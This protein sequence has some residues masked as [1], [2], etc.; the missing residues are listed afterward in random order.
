MD[1]RIGYHRAWT[2]FKRSKCIT[3]S[4]PL[5]SATPA[6]PRHTSIKSGS[7]E[8]HGNVFEFL[9]NNKLDANGFF[10]NRTFAKKPALRRN[11]SAALWADPSSRTGILLCR[12]RRH[13]AA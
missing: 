8:F 9:R 11:I 10:R 1:N 2:P 12:L 13:A 7:N 5:N 3:G 4:A 6:A